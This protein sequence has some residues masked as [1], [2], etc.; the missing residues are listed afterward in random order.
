[1]L[2]TKAT[3]TAGNP[4]IKK[5]GIMGMKAPTAVERDAEVADFHLI[6]FAFTL[7]REIR[8]RAHRQRGREHPGETRNQ[9]VMLLIV[10]CAGD[11]GDNSEDS[12]QPI[13][14]AIDGVGYP[15]SAA[16]MPAFA[17]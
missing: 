7:D 6:D 3:I 9:D 4:V 16:S 13:I 14:H 2:T 11:T 1:M 5:K 15:T 8:A 12:T 17:F 10:R